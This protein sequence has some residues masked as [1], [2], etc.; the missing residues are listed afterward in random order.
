MAERNGG[1]R[2]EYDHPQAYPI[3]C[4]QQDLSTQPLKRDQIK[5]DIEGL[6]LQSREIVSSTYK[7]HIEYLL[8]KFMR[9]IDSEAVGKG[10]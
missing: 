9:H 4:N 6:I 1:G 8:F 3:V 10:F 7:K 5:S 2:F